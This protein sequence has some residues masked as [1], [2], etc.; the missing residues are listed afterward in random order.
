MVWRGAALVLMEFGGAL[1]AATFA[2]Y[3]GCAL[4]A[5]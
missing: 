1:G 2:D 5:T 3:E 4:W